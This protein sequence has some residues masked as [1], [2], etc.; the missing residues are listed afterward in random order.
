MVSSCAVLPNLAARSVPVAVVVAP[1]R[2][3]VFSAETLTPIPIDTPTQIAP[4]PT[5]LQA[6]ATPPPT[7]TPQAT[8]AADN[9]AETLPLDQILWQSSTET[10]DVSEWTQA[11][12]GEAIFNTGTGRV[13]LTQDVVRTGSYALALS[14]ENASKQTQ[15]ARIF[16]WAEN[17]PEAYYSAWFY[18]PEQV[19]PA[20]WWNIFQFKSNNGESLP[21]WIVNVDT[22]E[23]S[24]DMTL[25][26]WDDITDT[27][28]YIPLVEQPMPIPVGEWVHIEMFVRQAQDLN[29]QV[30]LWQ[31]GVL[32]YDISKVQ[33]TLADNI[34]WSI[35]NYTDDISPA[36]V[37]IYAD[38]A[39][40]ALERRGVEQ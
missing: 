2:A 33:T 9:S 22:D 14:V 29:G 35:N 40:I 30:T 4:T 6:T 12:S 24:G 18:F 31:D 19:N 15:G 32:L 25:Y 1:T 28:H 3:G 36:N 5:L 34:H 39:M 13:E 37:T 38:D 21:T 11:Q 27:S 8:V 20:V 10:G 23:Q 17:A 16:R 26:L 7:A